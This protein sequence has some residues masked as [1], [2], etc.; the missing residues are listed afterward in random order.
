MCGIA[1]YIDHEYN[2]R[3]S[4]STLQ[5]MG[6]TMRE[7]G[8]DAHATWAVEHAGFAHRRLIVIDPEGGAQPMT[9]HVKGR[10]YTIVYNGELYNMDELKQCLTSRG[11]TFESRSDTEVVLLACAEWAEQCA[12]RLNGIFA[13]AVWCH[14]D[15]RL[16]MARDRLGVKP[17]FYAEQGSA[18]VFG[19]ELKAILAH[20]AIKPAVDR[21]GLAE[22][23]FVGP[24]RTP[25]HGI[26]RNVR[27][28]R[29]GHWL[30]LTRSGSTT[31]PYWQLE[32]RPHE[33]DFPTTVRR[34]RELL[35]DAVVRQLVSDVPIATLLSGGLD[36]SAV[37]A[38]AANSLHLQGR[39]KLHTFSVDFT[40]M[41]RYFRENAFQTGRDA[42]WVDRVSRHLGTIHHN[43]V[44][45][46]PAMTRHLLRPL[47]AR[48][49]PGMADIDVSLYM[50]CREIKKDATVALSGEAADEVFGGYPWFHREDALS[51]DTFPWSLRLAERMRMY[52]QDLLRALQP[53]QYVHDRYRQA[54]SEVPRLPGENTRA[55]R[56]REIS[57][58]NITRFL[59]TLLER[60][61]RMSM[62]ASLE[63]RVPFCDHRLVEYVWN[64]PWEMKARNGVAKAVLREAVRGWLP[65]DV[66][67]RKKSPYPST[68]HPA[69]LEAVRSDLQ[70][71]LDDPSSPLPA[72]LDVRSVRQAMED[73]RAS[74]EH[75]PWFGQIM[76]T[77][78]MFD[79]LLQ[80]N[81]WL[82]DLD[83]KLDI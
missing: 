6:A 54:L 45:D 77:P 71:V 47:A 5:A 34:V 3:Q 25:G 56:I 14:E 40:D 28:L 32:S 81:A 41:D 66:I 51:A 38:I 83:V 39:G 26:F 52:N 74:L 36:S 13:F 61:D 19:S 42:P 33:D 67:D 59:T 31:A 8:P 1:G 69:Y 16:I 10:T 43:I 60:K 35:E 9:R 7:R 18:F 50:F 11:H 29:P 20:H 23:L 72:L 75:R 15:E 46:T 48:D 65:D 37:S 17:L 22:V 30:S 55:A 68:P 73:S 12:A 64:I 53:E 63:V 79:Y 70:R 44:I 76:A 57:Y 4:L 21:E 78:Q 24:A 62:A 58:L 2:V 82:R 80:V 27:E 49:L